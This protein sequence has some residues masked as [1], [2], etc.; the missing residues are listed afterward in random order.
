MLLYN[1]SF[2]IISQTDLLN[3]VQKETKISSNFKKD[4]WGKLIK[5]SDI[6]PYAEIVN[7]LKKD[8]T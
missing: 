7:F 2:Y 8:M 1:N 6:K 5:V 4:T 3:L